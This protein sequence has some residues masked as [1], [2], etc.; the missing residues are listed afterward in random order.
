MVS[1]RKLRELCVRKD[2]T[3]IR[4]IERIPVICDMIEELWFKSRIKNKNVGFYY[5]LT[6]IIIESQKKRKSLGDMFYWEEDIWYDIIEEM[7][8][9][10]EEKESLYDISTSEFAKAHDVLY[11]FSKF[12]EKHQDLRF[13]QLVVLFDDIFQEHIRRFYPFDMTFWDDFFKFELGGNQ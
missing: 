13:Y 2:Y 6:S 10:E 12:W 8:E 11:N 1:D 7:I 3:T 9:K 4:R 5:I